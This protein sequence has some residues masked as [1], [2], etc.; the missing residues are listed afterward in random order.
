MKRRDF[1][2]DA[3]IAAAAGA[4]FSTRAAA[5]S[6]K[7]PNVLLI[8][9]DQMRTPMFT[10]LLSTPNIDRIAAEGVSFNRHFVAASVCSPSRAS[11][12]TGKH[13]GG[14]NIMINCD[15]HNGDKQPSLDTSITTMGHVFR[16][17]GYRT[18]YK[19]KWHLTLKDD[20]NK[21][22]P[23]ID[24]GFQ[25]WQ[26]PDAPFGGPP[27]SG[28]LQDPVYARQAARWIKEEGPAGGPWFMV[29]SLVNPHDI[30]SYPRYYPQRK[31][32]PIKTEEPP[33]NWTDDLSGKPGCQ[34]EYQEVYDEIGG[35]MDLGSGEAWR[36]YLDYYIHCTEDMDGNV[37][38]VM[39]ALYES[40]QLGNTIVVFTSDHGDMGGS[41]RLRAKGC[42]AYDEIMNTPLIFRAPWLLPTGV[43]RDAMASNV[44]V[45]PT[46]ASLAG[47]SM[48][49][50]GLAGKDLSPALV[51]A[52][53][54]VRDEVLFSSYSELSTPNDIFKKDPDRIKSPARLRCV[55]TGDW[56]YAR[57]FDPGSDAEEY[58][59]YN[60]KDDPLEMDNLA[61]DRGYA[62]VKTEMAGRLYELEE[63]FTGKE[64]KDG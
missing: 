55:R 33:P 1:I 50:E 60:I 39:D 36:R 49:K 29:C 14:H 35:K 47:I 40:G 3:A 27:Y 41:H 12:I 6:P 25:D 61:D 28:A 22:D 30:C 20:R 19:G 32:R 16:N 34:R 21:K 17:V 18:P 9:V 57:Y 62:K 48:K 11:L 13:P 59:L 8:L 58:E 43:E 7:R 53:A 26:P 24:Y 2:K 46:L 56:K 37:G 15:F 52:A 63:K 45:L 51:D 4:A 31:L 10:P 5:A 64:E 23:L 54:E 38:K 44:D 42:F